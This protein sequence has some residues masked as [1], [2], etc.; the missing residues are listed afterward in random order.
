M[1]LRQ[2]KAEEQ[3]NIGGH[4]RV[5]AKC[6]RMLIPFMVLLYAVNYLDRVNVGFAGLTMTRDLGLS[7]ASFGFG[8]GIF[9]IGYLFFQVPANVLL[10]RI[11]A[12]RGAFVILLAWGTISAANAL[13]RGAASLYLLRFLLGIA[14]AGFFPSMILYLTHWFPQAY[15]ARYT[16]SFMAAI[17]LSS[18]VGAPLSGLIL[19]MEG[20]L[21]LHGWQWLFLLEGT[22]ACALAFA[23]LRFL[24]DGPAEAAWLTDGE[25]KTILAQQSVDDTMQQADP[26]ATLRDLR[27][28]VL[29]VVAFGIGF[30][31]YGVSLWLPQILQSMGYSS[32][33]IGFLVAVLSAIGMAAMIAW[34]RS[35]D[36][37]NERAWHVGL[38]MLL[39]ATGLV[40][41]SILQSGAPALVALI[42]V[43]I[44]LLAIDGPF[45]SL[46]SSF[47]KGPAAAAGIAL[48]NTVGS[49]GAFAGPAI[50]G[51]LK[52]RTGAYT[53]GMLSLA[54]VLCLSA[55]LVRLL[56]QAMTPRQQL[57]RPASEA[58]DQGS[59]SPPAKP[60][61]MLTSGSPR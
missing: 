56:G 2:I 21:G 24:P 28:L 14:E 37:R 31:G 48:I 15:R 40:L 9:F 10:E 27:V 58:N 53:A 49:L 34:G 20:V 25:K 50:V 13:V 26:W 55:F 43:A 59:G 19:G 52:E 16:A 57:V 44:G 38:P 60:A 7:P 30:G 23:V 5:F 61:N 54:A 41:V 17:P 35:S 46:P 8:A 45:F 47:L 11:G 29:C 18:I 6:G 4:D 36:V 33:T 51:I 12:R 3:M 32:A 39:A 1:S 42:P 22:P